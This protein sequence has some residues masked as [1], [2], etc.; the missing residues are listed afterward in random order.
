MNSNHSSAPGCTVDLLFRETLQQPSPV[1]VAAF[2]FIIIINIITFPFTVVLN[3]LVMIAVKVKPRLRSHKSNILLALLASTDFTVGA[4]VQPTFIAVLVMFLL[5]EPSGYCIFLDLRVVIGSLVLSSLPHL[6][7]ISG[8]RYLAMKHPFMHATLLTETRLL[9]ASALSWILCIIL[10]IPFAVGI[11][12]TPIHSSFT[13]LIIVFIVFCHVTVYCHTRRHKQQIAGQQRTRETREQFLRDNKALK[14]T[15]IIIAGLVLCYMPMI[16]IFAVL[17]RY[18][19][20]MSLEAQYLFAT[21]GFTISFF[22]S[23]FNPV[24]Y[25]VRIRQFRVAFIELVRRTVNIAEAEDIEM[26]VFG[27]TNAVIKEKAD[28]HGHDR[29]VEQNEGQANVNSVHERH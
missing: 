1:A 29:N 25:S 5:E 6:A 3:A 9:A 7:L 2:I 27:A 20:A 13:G 23:L 15:T 18:G 8:E 11:P 26:R 10:H 22:N 16:V 21:S 17:L 24:I 28:R 4:I 19:S 12:V 14:L